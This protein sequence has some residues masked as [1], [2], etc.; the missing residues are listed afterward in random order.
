MRFSHNDMAD[1]AWLVD[2]ADPERSQMNI[3]LKTPDRI[4]L[5]K[6]N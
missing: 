5:N 4:Q 2:I 1:A 6:W 3:V